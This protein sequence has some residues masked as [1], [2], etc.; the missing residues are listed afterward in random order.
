MAKMSSAS[1]A[2][3][4]SS[5]EAASIQRAQIHAA[6]TYELQ[7]RGRRALIDTVDNADVKGF[8][9]EQIRW[10]PRR[11][12]QSQLGIQTLLTGDPSILGRSAF[13]LMNE[14]A[15]GGLLKELPA[16][17]R[18]PKPERKPRLKV[19]LDALKVAPW[20]NVQQQSPPQTRRPPR[21]TRPP[22]DRCAVSSSTNRLSWGYSRGKT[23]HCGCASQSPSR[24]WP[25]RSASAVQ[26]SCRVTYV[27]HAVMQ[28]RSSLLPGQLV[29][30]ISYPY[31]RQLM[32]YSCSCHD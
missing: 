31:P 24:V 30:F 22:G 17:A 25:G 16:S 19:L 3:A 26:C 14:E 9:P 4:G 23:C 5:E 28:Q 11:F 8:P 1:I 29:L 21:R 20:K 27:L 13:D 2:T 15:G 32:C 7:W 6:E 18:A 12:E 10:P